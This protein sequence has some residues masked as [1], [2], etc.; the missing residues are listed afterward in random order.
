MPDQVTPRD[1]VANA[2]MAQRGGGGGQPAPPDQP[3]MAFSGIQ[4]A[5]P[6]PSSA[7]RPAPQPQLAQAQ[8]AP[9]A[10]YVPPDATD[11]SGA[12]I[13]QMRPEHAELER[14]KLD[15]RYRNNEYAQGIIAQKV[16]P[17]EQERAI[18]Q[19]EANE[20]YKAEIARVTK[21]KE[22]R[23]QALVSAAERAA[24]AAHTQAQT[25]KETIVEMPDGNKYRQ[26]AD[27]VMRPIQIEGQ[28]NAEP[29]LPKNE[30]QL[31]SM[32][33]YE[34]MKEADKI[35]GS[36]DAL[37]NGAS[38]TGSRVPIV[39]GFL[40]SD[41]YRKQ[42]AAAER[43]VTN[44]LRQ[45]SGATIKDDEMDREVKAYFPLPSDDPKTVADKTAARKIA[46]EGMLEASGRE[47]KAYQTWKEQQAAAAEAA[48]K[49]DVADAVQWLKD[50]PN[51]P[52]AAAVRKRLGL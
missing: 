50:N 49:S 32:K 20:K 14:L 19:N 30:F 12:P 18:R 22:L 5:P 17:Y 21:Q 28:T 11:P 9:V 27:G 52:K 45:E 47:G 16:A 51:D 1:G 40:Q 42:R 31:K 48:R 25:N 6:D 2:L 8:Q 3:A 15:P 7:I 43:W 13:V 4:P 26:G 23:E 36:A 29:I 44:K 24:N 46:T 33:H 38:A 37:R 39:G 10:G 35:I 34:Q 41:A